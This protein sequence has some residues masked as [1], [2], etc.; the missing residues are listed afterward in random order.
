MSKKKKKHTPGDPAKANEEDESN[1][2]RSRWT[3]TTWGQ[4]MMLG[5]IFMFLIL[6]LVRQYTS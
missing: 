5:I 1:S 4:R 3:D 6:A 2:W